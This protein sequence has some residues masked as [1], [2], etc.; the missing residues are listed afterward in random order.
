MH[1][2]DLAPL[3]GCPSVYGKMAELSRYYP[4]PRYK[5]VGKLYCPMSGL[6]RHG[7]S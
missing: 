4:R 3:R 6:A 2:Q 7:L 1:V 5:T